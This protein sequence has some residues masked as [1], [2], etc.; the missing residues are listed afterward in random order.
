MEKRVVDN[1]RSKEN[2]AGDILASQI[3]LIYLFI[4][5]TPRRQLPEN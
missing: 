4:Q 1:G 5:E 3:Y 2:G